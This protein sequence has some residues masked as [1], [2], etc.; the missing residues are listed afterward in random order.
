MFRKAR[1]VALISCVLA[2]TLLLPSCQLAVDKTTTS[3]PPADSSLPPPTTTSSGPPAVGSPAGELAPFDLGLV[4]NIGGKI[5]AGIA[6]PAASAAFSWI[7]KQAGL[8]YLIEDQTTQTLNQITSQLNQ[9]STQIAAL[10]QQL[11]NVEYDTVA[12]EL[13]PIVSKIKSAHLLIASLAEGRKV[14]TGTTLPPTQKTPLTA[15]EEQMIKDI[16]NYIGGPDGLYVNRTVISDAMTGDLLSSGLIEKWSRVVA[17]KHHFFNKADSDNQ[18]RMY[19]YWLALQA[20]QEELI[21]EYMH[22][23]DYTTTA[24]ENE[25][26]E[27]NK[28]KAAQKAK[29]PWELPDKGWL[30]VPLVPNPPYIP[31]GTCIMIDARTFATRGKMTYAVAVNT[32]ATLNSADIT[33]NNWEIPVG[34]YDYSRLDGIVNEPGNYLKAMFWNPYPTLSVNQWMVSQGWT[35]MPVD[36]YTAFS[37][38]TSGPPD[39]RVAYLSSE[40]SG[41]GGVKVVGAAGGVG[42]PEY[43]GTHYLLPVR[44]LN[45]NEFYFC[46]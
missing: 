25:F 15:G 10:Q 8:G 20:I 16:L 4:S 9:L 37:F 45:Q 31:A 46:T 33:R 18:Q 2:V 36:M 5:A 24:I 22:Y 11:N 23:M 43:T 12:A 39:V 42:I 6:G 32:L 38:W 3:P 26:I 34:G 19:G 27:Y 17:G 30:V 29:I 21:I 13:L 35:E 7:M 44:L 1:L 14:P 28:A 41:K 40:N